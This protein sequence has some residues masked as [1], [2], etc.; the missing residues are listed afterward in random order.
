[1]KRRVTKRTKEL[2]IVVAILTFSLVGVVMINSLHTQKDDA[3]GITK[4]QTGLEIVEDGTTIDEEEQTPQSTVNEQVENEQKNNDTNNTQEDTRDTTQSASF[5]FDAL[6]SPVSSSE[7]TMAY[8]YQTTPVFSKT[9][10]QYRSDHTGIDLKATANEQVRAVAAGT[11]EKV[12][13]DEKLGK[14]VILSHE[15]GVK[16]IYANLSDNVSVKQGQSVK[17]GSVLGTVGATALYEIE[18]DV[19]VHF[20]I[21]QNDSYIDPTKYIAK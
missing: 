16:T 12:Y 18:D 9:F 20:A 6:S 1:M 4:M 13:T 5:S 8:S 15:G 21:M 3:S 10:N 7:I 11:V 17:K 14:T 2:R 19:H